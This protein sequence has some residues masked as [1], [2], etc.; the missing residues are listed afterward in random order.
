MPY[1]VKR[2]FRIDSIQKKL[3]FFCILLIIPL[4]RLQAQSD[5]RLWYSQP[6]RNW[7]EALPIGNGRLGAMIFGN[8]NEELLQ[9]NEETL[10]SGG[11]ANMNPNPHAV[12]YLPQVRE[13]LFNG[14]YKK[15]EE[16]TAKMQGVFTESYEPLGDLRLK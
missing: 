14:D 12:Q 6:A 13:A 2:S 3:F 5:L 7:N 1:T 15:A 11:P 10:W 9:L 4:I 16:L 8:P